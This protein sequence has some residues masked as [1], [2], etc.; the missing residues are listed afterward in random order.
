GGGGA[1]PL[2][3]PE[4]IDPLEAAVDWVIG[5]G[6]GASAARR[7]AVAA[8]DGRAAG[9]RDRSA[10][11]ISTSPA[12]APGRRAAS[13]AGVPSRS[14]TRIPAASDPPT[15]GRPTSRKYS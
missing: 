6:P 7:D 14:S 12:G 10:W 8:A 2:A 4:T 11:T 15:G 1:A 13:G 5:A 3:S 9:S